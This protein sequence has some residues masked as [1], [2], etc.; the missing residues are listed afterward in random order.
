MYH[1]HK[2]EEVLRRGLDHVNLNENGQSIDQ[3]PLP[4]SSRSL[5]SSPELNRTSIPAAK[6]T[7]II[8][9]PDSSTSVTDLDHL[10]SKIHHRVHSL[11]LKGP[12]KFARYPTI[13]GPYVCPDEDDLLAINS[14]PHMLESRHPT[15]QLLLAFQNDL[16]M[17]MKE[18][19]AIETHS[20]AEITKEKEFLV[21]CIYRE[22]NR[23]DDFREKEWERQ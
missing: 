14:G 20:I 19:H 6:D 18:A 21:Q 3:V 2:R 7:P 9:S 1:R 23:A 17:L 8:L 11:S 13:D 5:A 15:N 16:I 12:L 22:L 10:H 4:K